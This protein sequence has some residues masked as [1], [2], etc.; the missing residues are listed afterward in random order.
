MLDALEGLVA[1]EPPAP[2]PG[3]D[4]STEAAIEAAYKRV[5]KRAKA[6]AKAESEH[7]DEALHRIRKAA[8]KLRYTAAATGEKKVSDA[9][10]TIQSLLGDHQ[11][12][13]VSRAH[14]SQ[15]ADAAHAA[16]EDTFTYGLLHE[17]ENELAR[18]SREQLGSA[19]KA[20]DNAVR[21]A[22]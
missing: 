20:L 8:K 2:E 13:V 14:L 9:A 3:E 12:S 21:K 22:M 18:G 7:R 1:A 5:R 4:Q 11:D 19:L 16:A 15:Q 10:K 17:R 6:T